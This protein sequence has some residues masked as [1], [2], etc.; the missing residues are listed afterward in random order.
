M[1]RPTTMITQSRLTIDVKDMGFSNCSSHVDVWL[2]FLNEGWVGVREGQHYKLSK[3][4]NKSLW[5]VCLNETWWS[6]MP[7]IPP[8]S[9][10]P[11]VHWWSG[12]VKTVFFFI[13]IKLAEW[14]INEAHRKRFDHLQF[15]LM[16][17]LHLVYKSS[18][19]RMDDNNFITIYS[20]YHS[21]GTLEEI[22]HSVIL[23]IAPVSVLRF[24]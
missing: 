7:S 21:Y 14:A 23:Y 1:V 24:E 10:H 9:T 18:C 15:L 20:Y 16:Q 19:V 8:R 2:R 17:T 3:P 5:F 4:I 6:F 22:Q 13:K 11:S 12:T